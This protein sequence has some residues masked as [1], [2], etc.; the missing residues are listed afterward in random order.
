MALYGLWRPASVFDN[1]Q[2]ER[3]SDAHPL[4]DIKRPVRHWTSHCASTSAGGELT[5]S[6]DRGK[7]A[8]PAGRPAARILQILSAFLQR[9]WQL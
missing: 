5:T 1:L 6:G 3:P 8:L 7:P 4:D 9:R 2:V